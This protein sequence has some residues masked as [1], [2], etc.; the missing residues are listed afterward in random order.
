MCVYIS[1]VS[2][3]IAM[4]KSDV[5]GWILIN[6]HVNVVPL[7]VTMNWYSLISYFGNSSVAVT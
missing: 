1:P 4:L 7:V 2:R 6:L 3:D 5:T